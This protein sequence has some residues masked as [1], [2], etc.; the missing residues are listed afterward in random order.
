MCK[1]KTGRLVCIASGAGVVAWA[2][3]GLQ[4]A[5]PTRGCLHQLRAGAGRPPQHNLTPRYEITGQQWWEPFIQPPHILDTS[6]AAVV[7]WHDRPALRDLPIIGIWQS[8]TFV[9][10]YKWLISFSYD[11]VVVSGAL[12]CCKL[13]LYPSDPIKEYRRISFVRHWSFDLTP[14]LAQVNKSCYFLSQVMETFQ[15]EFM[16][17]H[18][19][20]KDHSYDWLPKFHVPKSLGITIDPSHMQNIQVFTYSYFTI[21]NSFNFLV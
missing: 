18:N 8:S 17:H 3:C 13:S 2:R 6:V 4:I 9:W 1:L 21:L 10:M 5:D 7:E 15:Q 14:L 19:E 12:F 11:F 20:W 16:K